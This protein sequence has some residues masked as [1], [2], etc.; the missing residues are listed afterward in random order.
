MIRLKRLLPFFFVLWT[1]SITAEPLN[2]LFIAS[3]DLTKSIG[4]FGDPIAVTPNLDRLSY[5]GVRFD[6]AYCQLPLCNPTR[7]SLMTGLRPDTIKVY[8]LEVHFRNVVPDAVTLPQLFQAGGYKAMRVGKIYHYGVPREIGTNGLD[9]ASSWN[10]VVNPKGRDKDEEHLITNLEPHRQ[11]SA[12]L[13][14]LAAE[15][16]DE[17]QTD[18]LIATE[19]IRLMKE[20][21]DRPFF[22]AA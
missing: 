21:K 2:V 14:W 7:A 9:D 15:G 13:S 18:G 4:C 10:Q 17:E 11:I 20:N 6:N 16:T 19:A 12:A 1:S 3:D 5:M 22:L 8:D